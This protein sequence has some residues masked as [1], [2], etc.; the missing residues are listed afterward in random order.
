MSITINVDELRAASEANEI[1]NEDSNLEQ[2]MEK[3]RPQSRRRPDSGYD[4]M[5]LCPFY[6]Y[7]RRESEQWREKF[8][9]QRASIT[10]LTEDNEEHPTSQ[11]DQLR[12]STPS[13]SSSP[14]SSDCPQSHS[15]ESQRVSPDSNADDATTLTDHLFED[16]SL[17]T[18]D[19]EALPVTAR[20]VRQ[21]TL[22]SSSDED[23]PEPRRSPRNKKRK[24]RDGGVRQEH[25][26]SR[27]EDANEPDTRRSHSDN[28]EGTDTSRGGGVKTCDASEAPAA[29]PGCSSSKGGNEERK[30]E[31]QEAKEERK[32]SSS[33]SNSGHADDE[34]VTSSSGNGLSDLTDSNGEKITAVKSGDKIK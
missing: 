16:L 23:T 5:E 15:S 2:G 10:P 25:A 33:E 7:T 32:S 14:T 11:G 21:D 26:V 3:L 8:D 27:T 34:R 24:S 4:S 6:D 22:S 17:V 29:Q 13:S 30:R 12:D 9:L 28:R 19:V 18:L 20:S 31:Q 1:E